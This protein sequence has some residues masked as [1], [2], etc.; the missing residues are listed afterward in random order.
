MRIGIDARFYGPL[1]K[2]LGR[3]TQKLIQNLEKIDHQNQYIIF[4]GKENFEEFQPT[5]PNFKKVLAD[6]RWYTFSEQILMPFIIAGQ[7]I[8]LMHFPHFNVPIFYLGKFIVTIHDLIITHFPTQKATTLSPLLYKI[9]QWGYKIVIWLAVKRAQK[10]ITV[11]NHTRKE[12]IKYF[13]MNPSKALVTYESG[14]GLKSPVSIPEN[15]LKERFNIQKSYLLYVGNAYPHKN[16]EGLIQAFQKLIEEGLDLQLV[17][18]G[19]EDY[20]FSRLKEEAGKLGLFDKVIFTGYISDEELPQLYQKATIYIFP[21]FQEGF[22][23]PPLEAMAYGLP[24]VSANTSCLPEI[25]GS[26]AEY[27]DPR[28]IYDIVKVVQKVIGDKDLQQKLRE[29]GYQQIN[30]FSWFDLARQ[31]HNL[32][33]ELSQKR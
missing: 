6:F 4:L 17:L 20:F 21:S 28:N 26:A 12:L 15:W 1:G 22:G 3:Y 19:K 31:T 8:D 11:S 18:V 10:I 25:L 24:V 23:L 14:N 7:K 30:K 27:F 29:R 5:N 16:L 13:K 2:G 32:Y 9:K 33:Q